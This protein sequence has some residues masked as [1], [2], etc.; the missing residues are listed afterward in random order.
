VFD[1]GERLASGGGGGGRAPGTTADHFAAVYHHVGDDR[2][3]VVVR[4]VSGV[5][6]HAL[7][8]SQRV[9]EH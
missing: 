8:A 2:G 3:A 9:G 4:F 1:N 7:R 6:V 5:R